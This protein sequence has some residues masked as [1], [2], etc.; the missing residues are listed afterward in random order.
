MSTLSQREP[1][2]Q[3]LAA[4]VL[5]AVSFFVA[6]Q[7]KGNNPPNFD[8]SNTAW[9]AFWNVRSNR[10]SEIVS[11]YLLLVAA[12]AL[13]WFVSVVARR[14]ASRPAVAS[15]WAAAGMIGVSTVLLG[16]VAVAKSI[17]GA[18]SPAPGVA[19]LTTDM[20]ADALGMVAAPLIGVAF[21]ALCVAARR[22]A[23]LPRWVVWSGI[24][25]AV[26]GGAGGV[27]MVPMLLLPVWPLLAGASLAFGRRRALATA[28]AAA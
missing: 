27:A 25:L 21:V 9:T 15:A 2:Y 10:V 13:V 8:A 5:F 17:S 23:A 7:L 14:V 24:A 19:R 11:S 12:G 22:S 1:R 18:P 28:T 26:L 3:P 20:G 16:A 6:F 4:A